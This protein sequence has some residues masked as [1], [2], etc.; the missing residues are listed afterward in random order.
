MNRINVSKLVIL[1]FAGLM[2]CSFTDYLY[3][4]TPTTINYQGRLRESGQPVTNP[5]QT[6]EFRIY[7]DP[8]AGTLIWTSGDVSVAVNVG[9]FSYAIGSNNGGTSPRNF[10]EIDWTAPTG[11]GSYWLAIY[12][13]GASGTALTPREQLQSSPYAFYAKK[14]GS[15]DGL[16]PLANG[17]TNADLSGASQG[18]IV[19]KG[20]SALAATT[21]LTGIIFGKGT[22]APVAVNVT[23]IL[24]G[25]G[26]SEPTA[27]TAPSGA[28]VGTTDTQ[29]LT[30]KTMSTG[31]SWGG[32]AVPVANGGTGA[33]TL[34]GILKGNG[35]GA[36]TAVTAP[37]GAIVGTTDTQSLTNKTITDATNTVYATYAP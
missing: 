16:L 5:T 10:S 24:K 37:S 13:G 8:S 34:T 20:A 31:C 17:G 3:S 35:T 6:L 27:V 4:A 30:N 32:T 36:F 28:L 11:A 22:S 1:A 21:G 2:L 29:T 18:G 23:G 25:N 33:T 26:A 19:Y 12:I 9:I 14:A 15:F 7:D